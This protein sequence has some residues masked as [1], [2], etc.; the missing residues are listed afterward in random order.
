MDAELKS[1]P[2]TAII[3]D[4]NHMA[5]NENGDVTAVAAAFEYAKKF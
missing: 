4:E 3:T 5:I 2:S 1:L